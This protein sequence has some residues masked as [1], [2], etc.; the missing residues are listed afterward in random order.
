MRQKLCSGE[1]SWKNAQS[2]SMSFAF[3]ASD[4]WSKQ[5]A[6]S[7][8]FLMNTRLDGTVQLGSPRQKIQKRPNSKAQILDLL[9][10]L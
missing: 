6:T 2:V 3:N 8:R 10:S 9:I 1:M 7:L 5:R 4:L